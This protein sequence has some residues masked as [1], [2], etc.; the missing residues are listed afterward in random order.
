[1]TESV[2]VR[3][4][5]FGIVGVIGEELFGR[6]D[7]RKMNPGLGKASVQS[8]G[9]ERV[10]D[11][12]AIPRQEEVH[13]VNSGCGDMEGVATC[14]TGQYAGGN[15]TS[16][17]GLNWLV[18]VWQWDVGKKLQALGCFGEIGRAHV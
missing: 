9:D 16:G 12:L 11:V 1:M 4:L 6:A 3:L 18:E 8:V 14:H 17:E 5:V 2:V 7:N 10:G 13:P 15:Q